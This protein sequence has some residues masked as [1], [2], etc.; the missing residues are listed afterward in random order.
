MVKKDL[1]EVIKI[2]EGIIVEKEGDFLVFK[3]KNSQIKKKF[4]NP[5]VKIDLKIGEIDLFCKSATRKDKAVFQSYLVHFKNIF[6]GLSE[7]YKYKLKVC[8][9]HF[10][11]NV[12]V[13]NNVL[14]IKNFF[15]EKIP[16]QL[17]LKE[18]VTVKVD[19]NII[20]VE[21][22]D[23]ELAGQVAADIES[24]TKR[25][26]FDRRIFQDGIYIIEKAG[27]EI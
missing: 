17:K 20:I 18:N 4:Q 19:G 25:P 16:R 10:P 12:S 11:M 3:S 8:S 9:G 6:N 13:V 23:K 21:S 2:P 26:G 5:K 1:H 7:P 27:N 15:G 24:I 14:Y 22:A